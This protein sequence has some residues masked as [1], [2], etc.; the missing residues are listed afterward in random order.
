VNSTNAGHVLYIGLGQLPNNKWQIRPYDDDSSMREIIESKLQPAVFSTTT[1]ESDSLL[2][3]EW[4]K[5]VKGDPA[6]Y[7]KK[8]V[9]VF[10]SVFVQPFSE[11][12]G[13]KQ[14][15]SREDLSQMREDVRKMNFIDLFAF[16]RKRASAALLISILTALFGIIIYITFWYYLVRNFKVLLSLIRESWMLSISLLVILYQIALLTAGYYHRNYNTNIYLLYIIV[17]IL[18]YDHKVKQK[19]KLT[20]IKNS[21]ALS[22]SK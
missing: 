7:V 18:L 2:K 4:V 13:F 20:G 6:E 12:D 10:L 17:L 1:Y 19:S 21:I 3:K 8:C 9:Y 22:S 16:L 11:G 5:K 14:S 15:L